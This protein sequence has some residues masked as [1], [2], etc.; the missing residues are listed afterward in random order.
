MRYYRLVIQDPKT[1][2]VYI[3]NY[4]GV[5]GFSKVPYNENLSTYTSIKSGMSVSSYGSV[6]P[7][8]QR[9]TMDVPVTVLHLPG[10]NPFIRV[11]GIGLQEIA[12]ASNLN[13]ATI[14]L[15]GGMGAGLPLA[16]PGQAGLLAQGSV[17]QSFGNWVNSD[18]TLDLYMY[19]GGSSPSSDQTTGNPNSST[20]N[21]APSTNEQPANIIFQWKAGD[22]LVTPLVNSLSQAF[23]QYK[24]QGSVD[25]RLV[26]K[27]ST[28]TGFWAKLTQFADYINKKS[29][30]IISG[31]APNTKD[32]TQ[33]NYYPGVT[34]S[35]QKNIF[36][37][38]DGSTIT[39]PKQLS[40]YDLVGQPT[41]V[42]INKVQVT[43][44]LR[45]DITVND[46]VTLPK[47]I[48]TITSGSGSQFNALNS[49][50]TYSTLRNNSIFSGTFQV[51]SV[52]HV[53]DNRSNDATGWITVLDLANTYTSNTVS[54]YSVLYGPTSS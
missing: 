49:G 42:Q 30:D 4:N 19:A 37:I 41:W 28:A 38:T 53:G 31:Y 27:G 23:P 33:S 29:L 3:P 24:I 32:S 22:S 36:T 40:F 16:S 8:A 50:N 34:I 44:I 21:I 26:W 39:Q 47:G 6:N 2:E 5:P 14:S 52:R 45:A 18:M 48:G 46:Y 10:G 35:L 12:Q 13:Y 15:Y 7:N 9:I 51:L 17:W 20:S 54:G 43:C 25:T 11:W 1:K